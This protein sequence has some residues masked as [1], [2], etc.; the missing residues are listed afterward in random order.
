ME[1]NNEHKVKSR[2][3]PTC[4][5]DRKTPLGIWHE[6][7]YRKLPTYDGD[8]AEQAMKGATALFNCHY[9]DGC[10]CRGWLDCHGPENLI[11]L[12][13]SRKT[14]PDIGE[15]RSDCYASGQECL[16]ANLREIET[17]SVQARLAMAKIVTTRKRVRTS[18]KKG[19]VEA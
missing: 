8:M 18:K 14:L 6:E 2:P 3:C 4:P 15:A 9:N 17:P 12:R 16:D 19:V 11:A 13:L 7:E 5:Y 10:L 1:K